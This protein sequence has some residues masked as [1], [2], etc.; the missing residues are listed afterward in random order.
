MR[1]LTVV[2][3]TLLLSGC[4]Q[5]S[6]S[7][8]QPAA[9]AGP[10]T[11]ESAPAH[12]A[13]A[14]QVAV[15]QGWIAFDR[16][17]A[18]FGAEGPYMGTELIRPDGTNER[19]FSVPL[20]SFGLGAAWSRDGEQFVVNTWTEADKGVRPGVV[21][22][23]GS[24][25]EKLEP[26]GVDGDFGCSDWNPDGITLLCAM[27]GND[28]DVDGIYT[29]R[30]DDL[31]LDRL[32]TSPFH[33]TEGSAGMCGGGENRAIYSPDGSRIA[34]VRQR[35]GLGANPSADESAAMEI[36]AEDGSDL[37]ELVEQGKVKSHPGSQISWSP[38]G[39]S[40]AFGS[41]EG[42]LYLVGVE[43]GDITRIPLPAEVGSHHADGPDWSPDGS[44]LVFSMF[45]DAQ[46]DTELYTI[47]PDGSDL[48]QITTGGGSEHWARW[49]LLDTP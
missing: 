3:L 48:R 43:T 18:A 20:T 10:I 17:D 5:A 15:P 2:A 26:E 49:G 36:M 30:I 35:C 4:G 12:S 31:H 42:D 14:S 45:T 39:T 1:R 27:S 37:R 19:S 11:S 22:V 34:Y 46:G 6:T 33:F 47:A 9:S 16:Y 44:R 38:D 13:T 7:S 8:G 29:L 25:F 32:T 28:P 41:Q 24:D 21:Q 23:D 40:I